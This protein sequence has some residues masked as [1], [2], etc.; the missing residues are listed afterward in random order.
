MELTAETVAPAL[1]AAPA[2]AGAWATLLRSRS[3]RVLLAI[4]LVVA[5]AVVGQLWSTRRQVVEAEQREL[6]S[7]AGAMAA[8]ADATLEAAAAALG[9]TRDELA[10]GLIAPGTPGADALLRAHVAGLPQ[11]RALDITDAEGRRIA[12]SHADTAPAAPLA[13]H[14]FFV[15]ARDGATGALHL[16]LP[17]VLRPEDPPSISVA[18]DWRD[19]HGRFGGVVMLEAAP[20]F[21]DRDFDRLSPSADTRM[22]IY[23]RD[24]GLVADGPGDHSREWA[25]DDAAHGLWDDPQRARTRELQLPGGERRLVAARA[26]A[27][28]PLLLVVSRSRAAALAPW[29]RQA[30]LVGGFAGSALLVTLL[31]GLRNAREQARRRASE[32]ALEAE[33]ARTLRAFQ[34]AQEG[35]WEWNPATGHSYLSPRMKELLGLARDA[36]VHDGPVATALLHPE[37]VEPLRAAFV[38]HA[39][40]RQGAFDRVFRVRTPDGGWRHVRT[41]GLAVAGPEGVLLSGTAI[42]VSD[43]VQAR[44]ERQ[45]LEDELGRARRMEALGTLAGGVAHDFNNILASVIGYGEIARDGLPPDS[46]AARPVERVLQAGQRGKALV[47]RILAFSRGAPRSRVPLRLQPVVDEVLKLLASQ[48]PAGSSLQQQRQAP[49]AVVRGDATAV[50]EAVMNLCTNGLQA[51][52]QGGTLGVALDRV[53]LAEERRLF[54]GRLAPGRYV[55]LVVEDQGTGIPAEV[56]PHLFEPFFTTRAA[57]GAGGTHRG[58]GLGLAVV[59]GVVVDLGGAIDLHTRA[60]Q[61]TRFELYLPWCDEAV[62][63][64]AAADDAATLPMGDGQALLVVDD[65]PALVDLASELLAGLGYEPFGTASSA[66]ALRRFEAEPERYALLLTDELMPGLS[67]TA[68]AQAVHAL[69]PGLPVVLASG[70]GGPQFERRAA[71]AGITVTLAKPLTRAELARAIARALRG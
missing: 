35:A 23:R 56:L 4:E 46:A 63:D 69:R 54:D 27:R 28:A 47:E 70:W 3:L 52:P 38:E 13:A 25:Q 6:A 10:R 33:Q 16:S 37:D 66:E 34:A 39:A 60:G 21:L 44:E 17:H 53:E 8:Q 18:M 45:R 30:W 5:L 43:E 2:A 24:L 68:L 9:T 49:D 57:G 42:D 62:A 26:L 22:A 7:L 1:P 61:G 31:M 40:G 48:L 50:F 32:A 64:D 11:F 15:A 29:T 20:D 67:G 59:H 65:E 12:S 71:G 14:E 36:E 19:A 41:R 51:M 58:T 55:R